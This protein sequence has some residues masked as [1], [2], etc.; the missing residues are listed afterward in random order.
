MSETIDR[1]HLSRLWVSPDCT[2]RSIA[3]RLHVSEERLKRTAA[4]IGLG[5]RPAMRKTAAP[6]T[7]RP[8]KARDKHG[9]L[10]GDPTPDQMGELLAYCL[11]R[12][13][14]AGHDLPHGVLCRAG[15]CPPPDDE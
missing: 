10:P 4:A 13:L 8:A 15:G 12:R 1:E 14:L 9:P 2:L 11:A 6:R 3:R 5:D 7:P